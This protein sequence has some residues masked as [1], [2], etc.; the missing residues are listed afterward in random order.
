MSHRLPER[1]P[2][3]PRLVHA[4]D[5]VDLADSQDSTTEYARHARDELALMKIR[6]T[7][8][9][10]RGLAVMLPMRSTVLARHILRDRHPTAETGPRKSVWNLRLNSH[11]HRKHRYLNPSTKSV[12]D[13]R[14]RSTETAVYTKENSVKRQ[15]SR[16]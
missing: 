6:F 11:M 1:M 10:L 5:R 9:F 13:T 14:T 8:S 12:V 15:S 16:A 7:V 4:A 2:A 3:V